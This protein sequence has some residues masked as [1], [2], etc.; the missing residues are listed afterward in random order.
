MWSKHIPLNGARL[1]LTD[2][3]LV[4]LQY[5]MR[6]EKIAGS[7]ETAIRGPLRVCG[8]RLANCYMTDE[9]VAFVHWLPFVHATMAGKIA[10]AY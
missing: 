1:G 10:T 8:K 6:T 5:S 7:S 4:T 3:C 9:V 2:E